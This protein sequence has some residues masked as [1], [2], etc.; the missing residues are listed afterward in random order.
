MLVVLL[1]LL[2]GGGVLAFTQLR[3]TPQKTISAYCDGLQTSNTQEIYDNLS[4]AQRVQFGIHQLQQALAVFQTVNGVK[5]CALADI[6]ENDPAATGRATLTFGNG[7]TQSEKL[8]FIQE[9]GTWRVSNM[10]ISTPQQTLQ[11]YCTAFEHGDAQG[12]YNTLSTAAQGHTS[13]SEIQTGFQE[14]T[15]LTGGITNCTMNNLQANGSSATAT[16][17]FTP[18]H[19]QAGSVNIQLVAESGAWKI[20][21][22]TTAP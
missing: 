17:T 21:S 3:S 22:S 10:P 19:G 20:D 4:S 12:L 18:V 5:N 15:L 7:S 9:N 6:Q 8:T 16:V 11:D 2:G 1:L 13:V 14:L